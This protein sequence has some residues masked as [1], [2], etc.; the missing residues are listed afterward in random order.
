MR[1]Y[2]WYCV[3]ALSWILGAVLAYVEVK[4]D[5][6]DDIEE[7]VSVG[8]GMIFLQFFVTL[9]YIFCVCIILLVWPVFAIVSIA[10]FNKHEEEDNNGS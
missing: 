2:I 8:E 9:L 10:K 4:N 6:K 1:T 5:I 3:I 7:L